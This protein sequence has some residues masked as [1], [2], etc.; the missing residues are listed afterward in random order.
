MH[1]K[2]LYKILFKYFIIFLITLQKKLALNNIY[3]YIYV[4]ILDFSYKSD[5]LGPS[6]SLCDIDTYES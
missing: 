6:L 4:K 5:V 2:K 1:I 3:I